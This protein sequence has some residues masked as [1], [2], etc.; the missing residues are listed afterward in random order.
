MFDA[1]FPFTLIQQNQY[2]EK[3]LLSESLFQFK[4]GKNRRYSVSV[5][6]YAHHVFVPK[7]FPST[8]KNNPNRFAILTGEY[9]GARVIRTIID[10]MLSTYSVNP[11][12]SFAWLGIATS[13]KYKKEGK[14]F[15][16]RYRIYKNVMLN[17]FNPDN[18]FHYDDYITSTYLLIN[19]KQENIESFLQSVIRMFTDIYPDLERSEL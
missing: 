19:R 1:G 4:T 16:Q 7:F 17:F 15:T 12:A 8:E 6:E 10:I 13:M 18:W 2:K 14:S 11:S 5:E 9:E 3:E